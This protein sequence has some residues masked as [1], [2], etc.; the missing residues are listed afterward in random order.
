M[1][2]EPLILWTV[3]SGWK[4]SVQNVLPLYSVF[5]TFALVLLYYTSYQK[6]DKRSLAPFP[7]HGFPKL[8]VENRSTTLRFLSTLKYINHIV[9]PSRCPDRNPSLNHYFS[10]WNSCLFINSI[11]LSSWGR[12]KGEETVKVKLRSLIFPIATGAQGLSVQNYIT[13]Q[14]V[15]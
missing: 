15:Q 6:K 9:I 11:H 1:S 3:V 10:Y 13:C 12:G 5:L 4:C 7:N 8:S 14:H 2:Y